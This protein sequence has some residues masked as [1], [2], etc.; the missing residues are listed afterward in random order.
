MNREWM[1]EQLVEYLGIVERLI[2]S[3]GPLM[4]T[5][6]GTYT[7]R[8]VDRQT[9]GELTA[10]RRRREPAVKAILRVQDP[11]LASFNSDRQ[12]GGLTSA[13]AA[14]QR[15]I[16]HLDYEDELK[17]HLAPDAPTLPA[18]KLHPWVWDAA[19]TF[20]ESQHFRAAVAQ[21]AAA[22]NAHT[23]QKV[24]IRKLADNDLMNQ[25]FTGNTKP[26]QVVLRLPGDHTDQTIQ[27]QQRSLRPF[28]EGCFAGIRNPATHETGPD[29]SEQKA[30]EH[31]AALSILARAID[32]CEVIVQS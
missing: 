5:P 11:V 21:A 17:A 26:G 7:Q 10:E 4:P 20:W 24:G 3:E 23:Q 6:V 15:G 28:A 9:R 19:R 25:V 31:L 29:W 30:L 16:G 12:P 13:R 18:D 32:E 8:A 2:N 27:S 14:V 22:I 1:R